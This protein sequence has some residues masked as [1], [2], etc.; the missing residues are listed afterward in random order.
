VLALLGLATCFHAR[1]TSLR[2]LDAPDE[3]VEGGCVGTACPEWSILSETG[4]PRDGFRLE[5]KLGKSIGSL[6]IA[7]LTTT[8]LIQRQMPLPEGTFDM[9]ARI[10][11]TEKWFAKEPG[12]TTGKVTLLALG[13]EIADALDA[14]HARGIVH[15]D[16]KPANVF[17]TKRGNAKIL[18]FGLAKMTPPSFRRG[19]PQ[20]LLLRR[21]RSKQHLTSPGTA[22]GTV[23]Y[24]SPEQVRAKELTASARTATTSVPIRDS[25]RSPLLV[26]Q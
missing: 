15:R 23:A 11:Q 13:I 5:Y 9:T 8:S 10:E 22:L 2:K 17:V 19:K 6:T 3:C 7:P 14:A 25:G 20:L 18:D 1:K 4:N 16:I 21:L 24:M 12:T 26:I